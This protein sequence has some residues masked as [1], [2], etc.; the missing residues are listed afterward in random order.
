MHFAVLG[1]GGEGADVVL[2][3]HIDH[4]AV[5]DVPHV[6]PE[7]YRVVVDYVPAAPSIASSPTRTLG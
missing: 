5:G 3:P 6:S 4:V 7:M 1:A 2:V